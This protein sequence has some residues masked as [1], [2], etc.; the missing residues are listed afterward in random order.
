MTR[1]AN[2]PPVRSARPRVGTGGAPGRR[3]QWNEPQATAH[4]IGGSANARARRR[5]RPSPRGE[6]R[7]IAAFT[8][9]R[10]VFLTALAAPA[11]AQSPDPYRAIAIAEDR[12]R[13]SDGDLGRYLKHAEAAVR[14]RAALAIGRLQDSTTV[15]DLVPLLADPSADVLHEAVFA[16]G[17]IGHRSARGPLE[18]ML[19]GRDTATLDLAKIGRASCRERVYVLV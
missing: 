6:R 16:L 10:L 8:T 11:L 12:R 19:G 18:A 7:W 5:S 3:G 14:A 13:L 1:F 9:A 17:Q 2:G 4:P 15:P